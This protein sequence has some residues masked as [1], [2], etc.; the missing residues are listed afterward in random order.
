M[1]IKETL[2]LLVIASV[3]AWS[4]AFLFSKL[5]LKEFYSRIE[6]SPKYFVFASAIV[7]IMAIAVV[8]YQFFI[9]VNRET[10]DALKIS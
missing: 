3:F 5:W 9:A 2:V 4:V 1:L 10:G 8:L 6:L 7:L